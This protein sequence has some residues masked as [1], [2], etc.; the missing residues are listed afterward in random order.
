[1]SKVRRDKYGRFAPK[2]R[3]V[4]L[5][6]YKT[7]NRGALGKFVSAKVVSRRKP[8]GKRSHW[9]V[10]QDGKPIAV[11]AYGYY[12]VV[13]ALVPGGWQTD[14][15]P[16]FI[17]EAPEESLHQV[18]WRTPTREN[19]F[20]VTESSLLA[21]LRDEALGLAKAELSLAKA[22]QKEIIILS[23]E[24]RVL[25]DP[26]ESFQVDVWPGITPPKWLRNVR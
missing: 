16:V 12:M 15:T 6:P 22:E 14:S 25:T 24:L 17:T 4:K 7:P 3:N 23:C 26:H 13:R 5:K 18:I 1:M 20:R 10:L 2:R 21:D 11:D 19:L 9:K 8:S